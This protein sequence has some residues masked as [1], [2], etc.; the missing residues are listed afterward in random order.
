MTFV[1]SQA[2]SIQPTPSNTTEPSGNTTPLQQKPIAAQSGT[3]PHDT[4]P[5]LMLALAYSQTLRS[6]GSGRT[7][8]GKPITLNVPPD[9]KFGHLRHQLSTALRNAV[10]REWLQEKRLTRDPKISMRSD[11]KVIIRDRV[12]AAGINQSLL[13]NIVQAL[14]IVNALKT[15]PATQ[16]GVSPYTYTPDSASMDEIAQ[17]Y[18]E[19]ISDN[20]EVNKQRAE[21]IAKHKSFQE[22]LGKT[23]NI[24]GIEY[25]AVDIL[26]AQNVPFGELLNHRT[27]LAELTSRVNAK[28]LDLNTT[29][30]IAPN[31]RFSLT[32]E[33]IEGETV[34]VAQFITAHGWKLPT[35]HEELANLTSVL[36]E[37]PLQSPPHGNFGGGLTWPIALNTQQQNA[38][39]VAAKEILKN[40]LPGFERELVNLNVFDYVTDDDR[41]LQADVSDPRSVLEQLIKMPA[42]QAHGAALRDKLEGAESATSAD[43]WLL[44]SMALALEEKANDPSP[45]RHTVAGYD[46]SQSQHWGKPLSSIQEGLTQHL[47]DTQSL[48]KPNLAP[49]AAFM[50]LSRKA[51]EV[52]V[53]DIPDSLTYGSHTWVD[54][55]TA[56]DRIEA[57]APGKTSTMNFAQ[58]MLHADKAPITEA[59]ERI[60]HIAKEEAV[61]TW[62]VCN[63]YLSKKDLYTPEEALTAKQAY[64]TR[65]NVLIEAAHTRTQVPPDRKKIALE[66]LENI[67]GRSTDFERKVIYQRHIN[68]SLGGGGLAKDFADAGPYSLLDL[69]VSG[70]YASSFKTWQSTDPA[71]GVAPMVSSTQ[72]TNATV[73]ENKLSAHTSAINLSIATHLKLLIS[74]LPLADRKIIEH[75]EISLFR[76]MDVTTNNSKIIAREPAPDKPLLLNIHHKGAYTTYEI[77]FMKGCI[78]RRP[79]QEKLKPV[80]LVPPGGFAIIALKATDIEQVIPAPD[81]PGLMPL[82][83]GNSE[84]PLNSFDSDRTQLIAHAVTT[85]AGIKEASRDVQGGITTFD[86]EH[87]VTRQILN[88]A[89]NSIPLVSSIKSFAKGDI[90]GGVTDLTL[91]IFGFIVPGVKAGKAAGGL[92]KGAS[93]TSRYITLASKVAKAL[94]VTAS[95]TDILTGLGRSVTTTANTASRITARAIETL[96]GVENSVDFFK[97]AKHSD[98]AHGSLKIA[99]G[100]D[101]VIPITAKHDIN[102]GKWYAYDV[103]GQKAY[104]PPLENFQPQTSSISTLSSSKPSLLDT[105][106]AQDNVIRM[107]GGMKELQLIADEVH[108]FTDT[109]KGTQRLNIVAHGNGA[110]TLDRFLGE[111]TKVWVDG[112]P[113][114]VNSFIQLLKSKG[115]DPATFDNV[116]LLI[117]HAGEGY[118][119]FSFADRFQ[120]AIRKPVKAFKGPVALDWGSTRVTEY[121]NNLI[122][123]HLNAHPGNSLQTAES[124]AEK[125]LQQQFAS[126]LD[127]EVKKDHGR[128]ISFKVSALGEPARYEDRAINYRPRYFNRYH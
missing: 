98:I 128:I 110:S 45:G 111:G 71:I 77:D 117:C 19:T 14:P 60:E 88:L 17:F 59:G 7:V 112:K 97:L 100:G 87:P 2:N 69:W 33:H 22:P 5:D 54:F 80:T 115:V 81:T 83:E 70:E 105:G 85:N 123:S 41:W 4:D 38:V 42:A 94:I 47:I 93:T 121:K 34:S 37:P 48:H 114:G 72:A 89:V 65:L 67:Y 50:L 21:T 109:Y 74:N 108:T 26:S 13:N 16:G 36:K 43:D 113:Y 120:K 63:G 73:Y 122:K 35:T 96:R 104:G 46:L 61:I 75:G 125:S 106:L 27:L 119:G 51:P 57:Q 8:D 95:P 66:Q 126:L 91:D 99:N 76:H 124:A 103:P 101:H 82:Q 1:Q 31:S 62:G 53:K 32:G 12:G 55:K 11:G 40:P 90:A 30:S 10:F 58:V 116:R 78:T 102:T 68:P 3:S 6:N 56:V 79:G 29:L 15:H 28:S 20:S 86:T 18:G 44:T 24:N 25:K 84:A 64:N 9:S 49:V 52:L 107:G 23:V 127:P 118:K 92:A 39:R